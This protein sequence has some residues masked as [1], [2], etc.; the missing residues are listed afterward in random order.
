MGHE[1]VSR[2]LRM[3]VVTPYPYLIFYRYF[4]R[5]DELRVERV[6]HSARRRPAL[7]DEPAEF[8]AAAMS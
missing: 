1:T 6:R 3:F 4:P 2:G 8:R 7:R 5:R